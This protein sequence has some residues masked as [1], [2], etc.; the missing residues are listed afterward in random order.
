MNVTTK[1]SMAALIALLALGS[2]GSNRA[3]DAND[4]NATQQEKPDPNDPL[5]DNDGDGLLNGEED[6]NQ[7]G[8]VDDGETDPNNRDT[9]GD[10]LWDG[11]EIKTYFTDPLNPD[12]DEDG[13]NDGREVYTCDETTFDTLKVTQQA[14]AN[15]NHGDDPDRID[16]LD[17]YNDSD[18]DNWVNIG[19]KNKGTDPC[20]PNSFP[21][22]E[23]CEGI[24]IA[25]A[26]YIPGGFDVDGDGVIENGFWFTP[27]PAS[28]TSQKLASADYPNF[29]E[30]ISEK[31]QVL[32]GGDLTYTTG[33]VYHSNPI[34]TPKFTDEGT[35]PDNYM[36]RLYGMDIPIAIESANIPACADNDGNSYEPTIPSNKQYIHILKLLEAYTTDDV[37]IKNGL[38]GVDPNVP[39]DYETKVYYMEHFREYTRDIVY[40]DGFTQPS[41][42]PSYWRVLVGEQIL[43]EEVNGKPL[44][45]ADVDVGFGAP[46]WM[47]PMAI[48]VRTKGWIVDLSFG[49]GSGDGTPN[50]G[51]IFRMATP[52]LKTNVGGQ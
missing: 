43:Y 45:W 28:A 14:P 40:L 10:G 51:V 17:P 32:N 52:Y 21:E 24:E 26:V 12:S 36:S 34:Y 19:E 25:G 20:D 7:N 39:L 31:Y 33:N 11:N 42:L 44:A 5:L 27:Y 49:V 35:N 4:N 2:C 9:D 15:K 38:L 8:I 50:N 48:V 29:N 18:G 23:K 16:A 47:D 41:Q 22:P 30:A 13:V 1:L 6:V 37:T 3:G 46:G